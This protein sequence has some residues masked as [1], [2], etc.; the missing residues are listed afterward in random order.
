MIQP[1][2]R[3]IPHIVFI[4][5]EHKLI[6]IPAQVLFAPVV[7]NAIVCTLQNCP[8][9]LNPVRVLHM[10]H[11]LFGGTVLYRLVLVEFLQARVSAVFV[12]V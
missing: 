10:V 1:H 2:H 5:S 9:A 12:R 6:N 3:V 7:I 11:K 8:D 4:Q